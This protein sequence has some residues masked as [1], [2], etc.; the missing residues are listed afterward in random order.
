[1]NFSLWN[2]ICRKEIRY[3]F[4]AQPASLDFCLNLPLRRKKPG[5]YYN[6]FLML[7]LLLLPKIEHGERCH[8]SEKLSCQLLLRHVF[9]SVCIFRQSN[10][11]VV[12]MLGLLSC[13]LEQFISC[14]GWPKV[15]QS[16][17]FGGDNIL[18]GCSTNLAN[19]RWQGTK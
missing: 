13:L 4:C 16:R 5:N 15:P 6:G 18:L 1:M 14:K 11:V 2:A 7:H 9:S 3:I 19:C 10:M 12:R 17:Q 8:L